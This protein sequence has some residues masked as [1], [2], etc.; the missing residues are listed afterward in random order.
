MKKKKSTMTHS[1]SMIEKGKSKRQEE[2]MLKPSLKTNYIISEMS[3][4]TY[5]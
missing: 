3:T 1:K 4:M 2:E 5:G